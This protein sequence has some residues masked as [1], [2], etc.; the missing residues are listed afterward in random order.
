[1]IGNGTYYLTSDGN[2]DVTAATIVDGRLTRSRQ[3]EECV[4]GPFTLAVEPWESSIEERA[5]L[6]R[7]VLGPDISPECVAIEIYEKS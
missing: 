7:L 6:V 1:M 3:H 5:E 4:D 2:V